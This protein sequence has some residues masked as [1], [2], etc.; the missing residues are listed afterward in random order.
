MP[1]IFRGR[2]VSLS[3]NTYLTPNM[4]RVFF[5]L[6]FLSGALGISF[7]PACS[8]VFGQGAGTSIGCAARWKKGETK[9][10][11]ILQ[12]RH[13]Q[14]TGQ[15]PSLFRLLYEARVTVL[16]S[17]AA[18]YTLQWVF[19][20][21]PEFRQAYPL[22]GD[23]LPVYEGLKMIYRTD[24]QGAFTEL[25]NWQEVRAAYLKLVG[26]SL[27][28]GSG[29]SAQR[30]LTGQVFATQQAVESNLIKEIRLYHLPYGHRWAGTA[31]MQA[32]SPENSEMPDPWSD[33][34]LSS[35]RYWKIMDFMPAD[36]YFTLT[37]REEAD[38][39]NKQLILRTLMRQL[40]A[41]SPGKSS[42]AS[43]GKPPV[44]ADSTYNGLKQALAQFSI[45]TSS[46]YRVYPATGWITIVRSTRTMQIS[47]LHEEDQFE[48]ILTE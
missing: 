7:L 28:G 36:P 8:V 2:P 40:P 11:S 46:E 29:D 18:G 5:F 21:P 20:L 12:T 45:R 16:D 26:L 3:N 27:P 4:K 42:A 33:T 17:A 38:S 47:Q 41:A 43:P 19:H 9:T 48:I 6:A 37:V 32:G 14:E 25:L 1:A 31:A 34:P 15:P 39:G 23:S 13:V 44:P 35:I 30:I 10:F 22:S 24:P